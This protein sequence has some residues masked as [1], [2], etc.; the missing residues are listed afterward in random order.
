MEGVGLVLYL[1][2]EDG[3]GFSS[4]PGPG[5]VSTRAPSLFAAYIS[6]RTRG[7]VSWCGQNQIKPAQG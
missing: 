3:C 4:P 1:V 6:S 2:V 5:Q 7:L